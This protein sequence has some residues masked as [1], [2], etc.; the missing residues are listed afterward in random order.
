MQMPV[1]RYF[2]KRD[3]QI[4]PKDLNSELNEKS[5]RQA[6]LLSNHVPPEVTSSSCHL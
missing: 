6:K 3:L 5:S 1:T 4:A 2:P